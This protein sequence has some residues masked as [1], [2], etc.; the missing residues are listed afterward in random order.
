MVDPRIQEIDTVVTGKSDHLEEVFLCLL[1]TFSPCLASETHIE[2]E[3]SAWDV[4]PEYLA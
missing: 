2:S 1:K 3:P 4:N